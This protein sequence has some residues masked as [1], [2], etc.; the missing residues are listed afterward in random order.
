M[1]ETRGTIAT[2]APTQASPASGERIR[3]A[4]MCPIAAIAMIKY[5][6]GKYRLSEPTVSS[7]CGGL[8]STR[9]GCYIRVPLD[10]AEA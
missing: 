3:C 1:N 5:G 4:T 8:T 2:K 7:V 6:I 10:A 9:T